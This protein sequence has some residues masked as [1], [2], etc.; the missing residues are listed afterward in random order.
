MIFLF[1][2]GFIIIEYIISKDIFK[3]NLVI[4]LFYYFFCQGMI[5]GFLILNSIEN[6][7][8]NIGFSNISSY[9]IFIQ[10]IILS[11][12]IEFFI[13]WLHRALHKI[14]LLWSLH[15]IH[16][17]SDTLNAFSSFRSH[18]LEVI[19]F[20]VFSVFLL[21]FFKTSN[22]VK[23]IYIAFDS[24][25]GMFVHSTIKSNLGNLKYIFVSPNMHKLHHSKNK[26]D[27]NSNFGDRLMIFDW[28]FKTAKEFKT[29]EELENVKYGVEENFPKNF[30]GQLLSPFVNK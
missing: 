19:I 11:I 6:K 15:K 2:F 20:G 14:P 17:S 23:V 28:I 8:G 24:F 22:N 4:D 10:L 12:F 7:Y 13:Y 26:S 21:S 30:L 5:L 29:N 16:H 27:Y 18:F 1:L 3:K 25:Y 9:N